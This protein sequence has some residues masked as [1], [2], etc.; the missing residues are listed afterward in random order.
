MAPTELDLRRFLER[1]YTEIKAYFHGGAEH[2]AS[3]QDGF[4]VVIRETGSSSFDAELYD[5]GKL[6][7][8][9][10]VSL[11]ASM[12]G[13][14]IS[15]AE[16]LTIPANGVNEI[17]DAVGDDNELCLNCLFGSIFSG[18]SGRMSID[19]AAASLWKRFL[20]IGRL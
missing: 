4:E 11:G 10:R 9:S 2:V 17:L 6:V 19:Q 20:G 15:Y 13:F 1:A 5:R 12:G 16:G 7:R 3:Q 14:A 18:G 8:S